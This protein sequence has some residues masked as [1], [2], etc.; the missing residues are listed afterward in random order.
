MEGRAPAEASACF[1]SFAGRTRLTGEQ[2]HEVATAGS[3]GCF[4]PGHVEQR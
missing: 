2:G 3:S 4:P 1:P